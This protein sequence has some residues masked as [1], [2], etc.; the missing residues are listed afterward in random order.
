MNTHLNEI[1]VFIEYKKY[2]MLLSRLRIKFKDKL[3]SLQEEEEEDKLSFISNN[4]IQTW[5]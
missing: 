2:K 1:L 5:F 4:I 3:S